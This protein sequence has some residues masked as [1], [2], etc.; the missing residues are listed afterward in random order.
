MPG[1]V[2]DYYVWLMSD[3]A[4]LGGARFVQM[5]ARHGVAINHIPMRIQDVYAGSGGIVLYQRAWQ[6]QAYRI[7]ELKRW[8]AVLSI[9]VNIEPRFFPGDIDLASC[10]VIA[11]QNAGQAPHDFV[12]AVM[13]AIWAHDQDTRTPSSSQHWPTAAAS[14]A[15]PC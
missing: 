3:W 6:R 13:A 15:R 7:H 10:M 12:N 4:Y 11:A 8:S 1:P 9:P 2:I 14:T 5:C